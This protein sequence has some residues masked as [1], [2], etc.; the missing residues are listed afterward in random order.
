NPSFTCIPS[1]GDVV[2]C[3]LTSNITCGLNNPATSNPL[4][5]IVSPTLPVSVSITASASSVCAGS[6]VTF[7]ATAVNPGSSP[8]YTWKVNGVTSGT[9]TPSFTFIPSNGNVVTCVLTSNITCGLNNPATSNSVVITVTP[10]LPVSVSITAS[11]SSVCAGSS[12]TFTATA[13]NP[14]SSPVYTWKVNGV[15]SGTNNPSFTCIPSNGDVVTCVLISSITCGLNNPATSNPLV[16]TVS[17]TLP[18]SVSV[19]ASASSVCSGSSVTYTATPVNAG[20][21]PTYLWKVNGVATGFNNP[22]FM[23]TPVSGDV[24]TCQVTSSLSCTLNNPATVQAPGVMV[25]PLSPVSVVVSV[26][27]STV[28]AG[29]VVTYTATPVNPGV[30]PAYA[31]NVN[32]SP[33]GTNSPVLNYPPVPGDVIGCLLTSSLTCTLNNPSL[34]MAPVVTVIPNAVVGVTISTPATS[35]CTGTP[36]ILTATPVN[37]GGSP[38]YLWQVNGMPAGA[39]SPTFTFIPV[40]GDAV[41]CQVTSSLTCAVSNPAS[42]N[43]VTFQ[44]IPESPVSVTITA[45]STGVCAGT[46][47]TFTAQPVNPGPNPIYQWSLNGIPAG[48]NASVYTIIPSDGDA[49]TCQ[50]TSSLACAQNNP[51]VSNSISLDVT[52]LSPVSVTISTPE[53]SVCA[54]TPVTVTALG[55]NPGTNPIYQ[56][57]VNGAVAGTNAPLLA[58]TPSDG[59]FIVC[60]LTSSLTCAEN[61]PAVSTPLTMT[62]IPVSPVAVTVTA[63]ESTVCAGTP[64]S[65]T[66]VPVNPGFSPTFE[67]FVNGIATGSGTTVFSYTP[68]DHD[69]IVC[70]LTSSL[71]CTSTNPSFSPPLAMTVIPL[72]PVSVTVNTDSW[73]VCAGIRVIYAASPVN[74][75]STPEFQWTVNNLPVGTNSPSFA[76]F[77]ANGE[78]VSCRLT[79]SLACASGNPAQGN[80]IQMTVNPRPVV[81]FSTCTD[82]VTLLNAQPYEMR[83]GTPTG[84]TYTGDGITVSPVF[85]PGLAGA[86][87]KTITYSY[88]NANHC[89]DSAN[90]LIRV[91]PVPSF[92]CG[93]QLTDVRDGKQYPTVMQ[94]SRCWMQQNLNRGIAISSESPQVNNCQT[95]KYCYQDNTQKCSTYGG[96][97]QWDEM[98]DYQPTEGIQGICPPGWHLPTRQDWQ[99]LFNVLHGQALAGKYLQ[100]PATNGFTALS[101]GLN[102]TNLLW[103]FEGFA[104]MFWTSTRTGTA[105]ALAHGINRVDFSVCDYSSLRSNAFPV[106]CVKD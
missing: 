57:K 55:E 28:C 100:D 59:D 84:G 87:V 88:E 14:G 44:V 41:V 11:A 40:D 92:T 81:T 91:L 50:L 19:T 96:L 27:S 73:V 5:I 37:A 76:Y 69:A 9:N 25:I 42:S 85:N 10:T 105:R 75:G 63:P 70:R 90:L 89:R 101:G 6:S 58:I 65:F 72:A 103:D 86:S 12:V 3:V 29:T 54:G 26:S 95:E 24:V 53:S 32:G 20:T 34:G 97:Y 43:T 83:G 33:A 48:P 64:V 31:W 60:K 23:Y 15:T 21:N 45:T 106:R 22:V 99:D 68:E 17:P 49:V 62:V 77:P 74:P 79:S 4:V 71:V 2:T 38:I 35:V 7:T 52:P 94:G 80:S 66:A 98:M 93:Q 56:W 47:V 104:T 78:V 39:N 1:N 51:A 16:I 13:V 18:V 67:W 36:V 61:N 30:N 102:Y 46:P 8:V 82:T